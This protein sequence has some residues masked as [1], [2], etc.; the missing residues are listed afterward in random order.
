MTD[1][2]RMISMIYLHTRDVAASCFNWSASCGMLRVVL[3]KH[4]AL[5][6]GAGGVAAHAHVRARVARAAWRYVHSASATAAS[7]K[8]KAGSSKGGRGKSGSAQESGGP[9]MD[10]LQMLHRIA[11]MKGSKVIQSNK[12]IASTLENANFKEMLL[13]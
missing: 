9:N 1:D 11:S 10:I 3:A 5:S 12:E 7:V 4:T 13:M 8:A 6:C 2:L